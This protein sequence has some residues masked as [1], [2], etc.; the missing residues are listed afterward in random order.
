LELEVV[1]LQPELVILQQNV[2]ALQNACD[3][4]NATRKVA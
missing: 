4:G 1:T 3:D 2:T